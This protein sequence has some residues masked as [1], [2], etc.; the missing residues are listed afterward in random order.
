MQ[1]AE[2]FSKNASNIDPNQVEELIEDLADATN[3][4]TTGGSTVFATDLNTTNTIVNST[5]TYLLENA[6]T[7]NTL[8]FNEVSMRISYRYCHSS[9]CDNYTHVI[10][11]NLS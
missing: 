9:L 4:T 1:A 3:S 10:Q 2:I 7:D 8:A 6:M 11:R 5:L